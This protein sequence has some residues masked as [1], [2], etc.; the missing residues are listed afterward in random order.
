MEGE[1]E[2]GGEGGGTGG[3]GAGGAGTGGAPTELP[4]NAKGTATGQPIAPK[5][6]APVIP[7]PAARAL[8]GLTQE[9]FDQRIKAERDRAEKKWA[10][11]LGFATP[12]EAKAALDRAKELETKEKEKKLSEMSELER[13]KT[14]LQEQADENARLKAE[15]EAA[16][17][18]VMVERQDRFVG[19]IANEYVKPKALAYASFAFK[20]HLKSLPDEKVEKMTERDVRKFFTEFVKENPELAPS[21]SADGGDATKPAPK[22]VTAPPARRPITNGAP[23]P[24]RAAP[25]ANPNGNGGNGG[26]TP[27]PGRPN[28]MSP[29]EVRAYA[30]SKGVDYPGPGAGGRN[31][32]PSR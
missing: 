2:P 25:P 15:A 30:A 16:Q 17:E 27:L 1:N 3:A 29:A 31:S 23:P 13:Y 18:S 21:A 32:R 11:A 12:E 19:N 10:T 8:T 9:G 20:T 26:K 7:R 14:Q 22:T 4:N 24:R 5:T 28:S 6:A